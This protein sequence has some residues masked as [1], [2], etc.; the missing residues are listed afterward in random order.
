[1]RGQQQLC[2]AVACARAE[3]FAKRRRATR[4]DR[5]ARLMRNLSRDSCYPLPR[6]CGKSIHAEEIALADLDAVVTQDAVRG[7]GME[8]EVRQRDRAQELLSLQG[9]RFVRA[10]GE[11]DVLVLGALELLGLG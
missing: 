1:M 9:H 7:R 2:I 6:P 8:I 5:A 4:Q 11:G 3:P 10:G